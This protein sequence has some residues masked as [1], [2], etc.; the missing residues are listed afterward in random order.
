MKELPRISE[1]LVH[2]GI[3][4]EERGFNP[5]YTLIGLDTETIGNR[6]I[7]IKND[8]YSLQ[9]VKNRLEEEYFYLISKDD[10]GISML[11]QKTETDN[12]IFNRY[13]Y[14]T[15]HNLEFDLGSLLGEDFL[16]I[17]NYHKY[18]ERGIKVKEGNVY[19]DGW[20]VKFTLSQ[21]PFFMFRKKGVKLIFTDSRNWFK[22]SLDDISRSYFNIH[23]KEKPSYIGMRTPQTDQEFIDFKE[24]A[25]QDARIQFLITKKIIEM[26]QQEDVSHSIT[27]ASFTAKIFKRKFLYDRLFLDRNPEI[28]KLI[29]STYH[30]ARFESIGRGFFERKNMYDINSLYPYAMKTSPLNF[31]NTPYT[32]KSLND[33][34]HGSVGFCRVN[35]KYNDDEMYPCLPVASEKLVFP[36][37]GTSYCTTFELMNALKQNV[38][39]KNSIIYGFDPSDKDIDHPLSKFVDYKY[40]EKQMLSHEISSLEKE[41]NDYNLEELQ[42]LYAEYL[43]VKLQLNSLYGKFAQRNIIFDLESEKNIEIAGAMFK[44]DFASL[45]TGLSRSIIHNYMR[46][47]DS[48][49]CD[50]DSII[51]SKSFDDSD[52]LGDLRKEYSDLDF[53]IVRSKLYFGV[54]DDVVKKAAK[55]GFRIDKESAYRLLK[56]REDA[57]DIDYEYSRM[58]KAM[59]SLKSTRLS[60]SLPRKWVIDNFKI[61]LDEDGKRSFNEHLVTASD[62]LTRNTLSTPLQF[63]KSKI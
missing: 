17:I 10:I 3:K 61:S 45:I 12:F 31:S 42:R 22:G 7:N 55:H 56:S 47:Y 14:I 23:K 33:V 51:T 8:I 52:R 37:Q 39:I 43:K 36:L 62:L 1:Y 46:Q 20:K 29:W 18:K 41:N 6:D 40:A 58:T 50:T 35:F 5:R 15:A 26:H 38:E 11:D 19:Y 13:S 24:Y 4:P 48:I 63:V 59:E 21:S 44:P 49:Y 34:E 16:R 60:H 53:I 25:M 9:L 27:P 57:V 32:K 54:Q 2:Y 28:L 30:G